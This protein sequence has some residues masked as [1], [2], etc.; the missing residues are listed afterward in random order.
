M[1]KQSILTRGRAPL[2]KS[3]GRP[4]KTDAERRKKYGVSMA[5][6]TMKAI[7]KEAKRDNRTVSAMVETLVLEALA[8]RGNSGKK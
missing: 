3:M 8:G 7:E 4:K 5:Q 6:S 1:T 2:T